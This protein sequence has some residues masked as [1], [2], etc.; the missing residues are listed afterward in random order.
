MKQFGFSILAMFFAGLAFTACSSDDDVMATDSSAAGGAL[1]FNSA[2]DGATRAAG[3]TWDADDVIGITMSKANT[4]ANAADAAT[5]NTKFNKMYGASSA[6]TSVNF[7]YMDGATLTN[8]QSPL[9]KYSN[10]TYYFYAYYPYSNTGAA[11][12]P[13]PSLPNDG[14]GAGLLTIE[15]KGTIQQ[16]SNQENID[17]MYSDKMSDGVGGEVKAATSGTWTSN[18]VV[19]LVFKH[20][21]SKVDFSIQGYTGF[22]SLGTVEGMTVELANVKTTGTFNTLTGAV[23]AD[24]L[25]ATPAENSIGAIPLTWNEDNSAWE[26]SLIILPQDMENTLVNL[27]IRVKIENVEDPYVFSKTGVQLKNLSAGGVKQTV[28]LKLEAGG[29]IAIEGVT[30]TDWDGTP[31]TYNA[32][33]GQDTV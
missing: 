32:T 11:A 13:N 6:G 28:A 20:M 23:T 12:E 7:A 31:G 17:F 9:K 30:I 4:A 29:T 18:E 33:I 8:D 14:A 21:M 22:A 2:I 25:S 3:T 10:D 15:T 5:Y 1:S 26:K 19:S 24:D 27:V 16:G